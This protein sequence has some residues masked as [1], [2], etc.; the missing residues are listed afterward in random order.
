VNPIEFY[1]DLF[2]YFNISISLHPIKIFIYVILFFFISALIF[3]ILI[4]T[5]ISSI[6]IITVTEYKH[7]IKSELL[8]KFLNYYSRIRVYYIIYKF[9]Y[10]IICL[11]LL[12][13][14]CFRFIIE[15]VICK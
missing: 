6:Y 15:L 3:A 13:F 5:N 8:L 4:M 2:N 12:I 9:I 14:L 7:K 11:L 10:F 1:Q